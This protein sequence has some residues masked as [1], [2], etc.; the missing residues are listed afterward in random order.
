M[1]LRDILLLFLFGSGFWLAGTLFYRARGQS[2]FETTNLRYWINFIVTPVVSAAICVLLLKTLHLPDPQWAAAA[3]L[4]AIPGMIGE[5]LILSRFTIFLPRMHVESG[6]RYGALLFASYA[7]FLSLCE[8][9]T[10]RAG[11]TSFPG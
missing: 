4:I 6:G 1:R 2:V 3:L 11:R 5:A 9:V 10:L 7:L 8:V